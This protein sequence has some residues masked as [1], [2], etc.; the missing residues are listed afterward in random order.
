MTRQVTPAGRGL[1]APAD[2][3]L[4]HP[5]LQ[6]H[7]QRGSERATTP[8]SPQLPPARAGKRPAPK[9]R[10]CRS[11]HPTRSP[12]PGY[13]SAVALPKHA[14]RYPCRQCAPIPSY[15][16]PPLSPAAGNWAAPR[17]AL[18]SPCS[19]SPARAAPPT[20]AA[21]PLRP[22]PGVLAAPPPNHELTFH[23][24]LVFGQAASL[25]AR[26]PRRVHLDG[27][28][29]GAA[30]PPPLACKMRTGDAARC[31]A[32]LGEAPPPSLLV[33]FPTGEAG[34]GAAGLT[35][36]L[37]ASPPLLSVPATISPPVPGALVQGWS[38]RLCVTLSSAWT[39]QKS[40]A[41]EETPA[42]TVAPPD[43]TLLC[44]LR[45]SNYSTPPSSSSCCCCI[46][47][48]QANTMVIVSLPFFKEIT[49]LH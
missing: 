23:L 19:E 39:A 13:Y 17:F 44:E 29:Q 46:A 36:C 7:R 22:P 43:C 21:A 27:L 4:N 38:Q 12:L 28:W 20:P 5:G 10:F 9:D 25:A 41:T 15:A 47:H 40:T 8:W 16:A 37:P 31:A 30:G 6:V 18:R 14:P 11:P 32:L 2:G 42:A 34:A 35:R 49:T 45:W 48:F 33:P 3:A 24:V 1:P 26:F